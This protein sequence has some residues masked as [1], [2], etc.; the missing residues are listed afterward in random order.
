MA[1]LGIRFPC[2]A[3]GCGA[4][5]LPRGLQHL[6]QLHQQK[7]D[8][9]R[10]RFYW[11]CKLS[12]PAARPFFFC[13][14]R[15]L[16]P[17]DRRLPG[18]PTFDRLFRRAGPEQH[19]PGQRA[20]SHPA[21]HPLGLPIHCN[22][23]RLEVDSERGLRL[24]EQSSPAVGRDRRAHH[25]LVGH[26]ACIS[27][28]AFYQHLVRRPAVDGQHP[29]RAAND[30]QR[31]VR[32]R[33]N[34]RC[35]RLAGVLPHHTAPCARG[36]RPFAGA[37]HDLGFQQFRPD[38]SADRR[39]PGG[40]DHHPAY[41]HLQYGLD[42]KKDRHGQRQRGDPDVVPLADLHAVLQASRPLGQGG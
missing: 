40:T 27:D 9:A 13:G 4:V 30:P 21:H 32:G 29:F 28:P 36:D 25:V 38:L 34:R 15:A 17:L 5:C 35:K 31:P 19:S 2:A 41:L 14:L 37:A 26:A 11:P 24:F 1:R 10:L 22:R 16:D 20:L 39:R 33:P 7:S 3:G 42:L 12:G 18:S 6:V 23:V 8:P